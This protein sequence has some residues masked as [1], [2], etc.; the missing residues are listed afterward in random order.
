MVRVA[1]G[2]MILLTIVLVLWSVIVAPIDQY[3]H[4]C[5][6]FS[7]CE[8]S[9]VGCILPRRE[10]HHASSLPLPVM[11]AVFLSARCGLGLGAH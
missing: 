8:E 10:L 6:D 1:M 4:C 7:I 2:C 11:H 5:N 3:S 9:R